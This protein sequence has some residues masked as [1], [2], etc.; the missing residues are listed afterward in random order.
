MNFGPQ[1]A[2]IRNVASTYRK[3]TFSALTSYVMPSENFNNKWSCHR[4]LWGISPKFAMW[5][6]HE[7]N[8]SKSRCLSHKI[9]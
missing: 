2:K 9:L 8:G 6:A 5:C 3:P 4:S 1:T 7:N